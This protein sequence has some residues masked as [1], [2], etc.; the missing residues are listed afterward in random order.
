[1]ANVDRPNGFRPVGTISGSPWQGSVQK[2]VS[3]ADNLFLGDLV[4]YQALGFA[5][6]GDGA[7][8]GV[9]RMATGTTGLIVGV[10]VGWEPNPDNLGAL[11]HVASSTRGVY[12]CTAP[13]VILEAQGD[14]TQAIPAADVGNNYDVTIAAGD[15]TTGASNMEVD[16]D[17]EVS[18]SATPLKLIQV[19]DT[20]DNDITAANTKVRVLINLHKFKS[21]T[22]TSGV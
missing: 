16:S 5:A 2:C 1:M 9:D 19:V 3:D 14:D 13:D 21:D 10:V 6:G 15:T 17:S 8:M 12:I 18:T 11:Y 4:I 20:P 22:G 7:Y